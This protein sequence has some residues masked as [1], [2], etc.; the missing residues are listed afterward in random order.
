MPGGIIYALPLE[1]DMVD[2]LIPSR[3]EIETSQVKDVSSNPRTNEAVQIKS[4]NILG[5]VILSKKRQAS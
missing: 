4:Q 5:T 3:R 1:T 2:N